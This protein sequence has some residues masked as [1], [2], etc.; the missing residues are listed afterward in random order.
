MSAQAYIRSRRLWLAAASPADRCS[1][2]PF[3]SVRH[4][5]AQARGRPG[6]DRKDAFKEGS[7]KHAVRTGLP[8]GV[9]VEGWKGPG[10]HSPK[11][12]AD[13]RS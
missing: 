9:N 12:P 6:C 3:R 1:R 11:G 8:P 4:V 5:Q 7:V 13:D 10:K 2:I